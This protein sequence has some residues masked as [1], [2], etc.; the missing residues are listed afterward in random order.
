M[1]ALAI[2]GG[3][4]VPSSDEMTRETESA[5]LSALHT[6]L[7]AGETVLKNNGTALDAVTQAVCALEDDPLF[8]AG[9]GAVFNAEG[10]QEMD[11]AVMVGQDRRAGAVAGIFGPRNP[12]RVAR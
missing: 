9:K 4:G 8:N 3:A 2:H 10:N 6:C 5:I 11:A 12:V 1:Y 7:E